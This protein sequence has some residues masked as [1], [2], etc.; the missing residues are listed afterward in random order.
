MDI[1]LKLRGKILEYSLSVEESIND[2]L[3]L[4]LGIYDKGVGTR[5]FSSKNGLTFKNKIDLLF[6]LS[7]LTKDENFDFELLM[8]FRN[9]FLHD[10]NCN[11]FEKFFNLVDN[12]IKNKIMQYLNKDENIENEDNCLSAVNNLF[13]KNIKTLQ[14]RVEE[15]RDELENKKEI[16]EINQQH[17]LFQIDLFFD[18]INE[19]FSNLESSE[20][21]EEK[22]RQLVVN[23][24][25]TCSKYIDKYSKD[26][27]FALLNEKQ[28]QFFTDINSLKGYFGIRRPK[29]LSSDKL[30]M[31]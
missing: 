6:D 10:I 23:I 28:K 21:D 17:V 1:N 24:S 4:N 7:I 13:L 14:I 19:I 20:L 25:R 27:S 16:L 9:K 2:L 31:K 22:V 8:V 30:N 3:L 26:E 29:N 18:L 15:W 5:L 11:S 12:N